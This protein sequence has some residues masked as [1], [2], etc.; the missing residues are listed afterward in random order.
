MTAHWMDR[1]SEYVDGELT[2]GEREACEAHL[3]ACPECREVVSE[4]RV[5][6][7]EARVLEDRPPAADLWP[8]IRERLGAAP[9][10][11][12]TGGAPARRLSF[13]LP[14]LIA[15]G[16]AF[17]VVG[18]GGTLA[19]GARGSRAP[20]ATDPVI[21]SAP[22]ASPAASVPGE[23]TWDRA[24]E[25][26]RGVLDAGRD[27]L[28]PRTVAVLEQSLATIDRALERSRQALAADPANPYLNAHVQQTMRRKV[29]L[30]RQA[31]ALVAAQS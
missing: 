15:A 26:L 8:G 7:A 11:V 16:L 24:I 29:E 5:I 18:A 21:A 27:K 3:L 2:A 28:D 10:R 4:L 22:A 25:D 13:S 14:Q 23:E 12:A 1:L 31:A 30:L 19:I 9:L 17:A 6:A 20:V